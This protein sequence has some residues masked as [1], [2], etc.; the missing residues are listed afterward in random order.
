MVVEELLAFD[1]EKKDSG[2]SPQY[3]VIP[4]GD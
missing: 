3:V 2:S 1:S 4:A